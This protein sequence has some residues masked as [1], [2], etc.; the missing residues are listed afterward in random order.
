MYGYY[1]LGRVAARANRKFA[2]TR[3]VLR[4]NGLE[5]EHALN[6]AVARNVLFTCGYYART[7]L[8]LLLRT[9]YRDGLTRGFDVRGLEAL[10]TASAQHGAV[11]VAPHLGDFELAGAVLKKRLD[12]RPVVCTQRV[13]PA[14]RRALY[15]QLRT[16]CGF[17]LRAAGPGAYGVL[18]ADLRVGRVVIMMLDR[19]AARYGIDIEFLGRPAKV[20]TAPYRLAALAGAPMLTAVSSR[21]PDGQRTLSIGAAQWPSRPDDLAAC[22]QMT[23][24]A[25]DEV[26]AG[27][28]A[29]PS[30]W[31]VPADASQLPWL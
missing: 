5:D 1:V 4:A 28:L 9:G 6:R 23:Q 18:L 22:A 3:D 24:R 15:D 12:T 25:A 10:Q 29:Q 27:I 14:A 30:Q 19:R 31:H 21:K 13:E 7:P 26:S 8:L 20:S 11:L 16:A 17:E 2:T